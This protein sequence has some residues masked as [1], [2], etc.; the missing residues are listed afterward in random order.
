MR[1]MHKWKD[2]V[3]LNL[4]NR[5]IFFL[6]FGL[7]VVGCFVFALGV[8]VGRRVEVGPGGEVAALSADS[9]SILDGHGEV[10]TEL[11]FQQGLKTSEIDEVPPTRDLEAEAAA[12]EAEAMGIPTAAIAQDEP[13]PEAAPKAAEPKPKA[14]PKPA[15][16]K[17]KPAAKPSKKPTALA[18]SNKSAAKDKPGVRKFTLQMKAFAKREQADAFAAELNAKGH[19]VRVESQEV[20][21]RLWHRV[22]AGSFDTWAAGI[23]AKENFESKEKIIAY[24]VRK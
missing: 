22:R 24:V 10:E 20:K 15:K 4:D 12:E 23:A 19:S 9:L 18:S 2:K 7:S 3:E 6:F 11:S 8:M 13:V 1:E 17:A 5:Q 21:G 14:E 16:P